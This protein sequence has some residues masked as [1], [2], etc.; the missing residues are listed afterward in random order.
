MQ[1]YRLL[2]YATA[3]ALAALL[4]GCST[5]AQPMPATAK[6]DSLSC[7]LLEIELSGRLDRPQ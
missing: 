6:L 3:S 2:T 5:T 1:C 4:L 7:L